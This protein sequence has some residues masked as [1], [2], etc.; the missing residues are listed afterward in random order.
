MITLNKGIYNILSITRNRRIL[1]VV[2]NVACID[3]YNMIIPN[4]YLGNIICANNVDFL[5]K[6]NIQSIVNCTENEPFNDYFEDKYK[7]R[8]AINDSRDEN[9]IDNFKKEIIY[10]INFIDTS[11]NENRA[12]YV[13]CYWGLMRSA[14]VV[15][16]Y[17]IKK[18]NLTAEESINII[19]EQRPKA[20]V[21][22]YNF[23]DVLK[24][25]ENECRDND[26]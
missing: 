13:H 10:A 15:A 24:Y 1:K 25:V 17:L 26:K 7:Y 9:N 20:L 2:N 11:I 6:N 22:F 19:K 4:L 5:S 23:N 21:S 18:Y 16:A 14:T 12:V 8:L 3:D